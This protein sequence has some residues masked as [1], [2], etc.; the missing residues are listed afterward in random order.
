MSEL[1]ARYYQQECLDIIHAKNSG[2]YLVQMCC[3]AG[4]TFTFSRIDR[5]GRV[6]IMAHRRELVSQ[7]AKYYGCEVGYE[8]GKN[9]SNGEEVVVASVQT[10]T[11]RLDRFDPSDFDIIIIDEAHNYKAKTFQKVIDYFTP[12]LCL[13][14]TATPNRADGQGLDDIFEEIIFE[15]PI[16]RG[17]KEGFLVPIKCKR[18]TL[19]YDLENI[20]QNAGDYNLNDLSDRMVGT[21]FGISQAHKDHARGKTLVFGVDVDHCKRISEQ[22]P[23]SKYLHGGTSTKEREAVLHDFEHGDLD[24]LVNCMLFTEG[25]DIPCIETI[26]WARPTKSETLYTQ[27]VCRGARLF[28][29]KESMLLIDC[30]DA[31]A[32]CDLCSAPTLLGIDIDHLEKRKQDALEEDLFNLPDIVAVQSDNLKQWIKNVKH[33]DLWRKKKKYKTHNVNYYKFPNGEL[34]VG[35]PNVGSYKIRPANSL[36]KTKVVA[37]NGGVSEPM[38]MQQAFD[39]LHMYLRKNHSEHEHLWNMQIVKK[40]GKQKSTPAQ[41]AQVERY[42][43]PPRRLTKMEASCV[44][45]RKW[46]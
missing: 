8:Q 2:S 27:G 43:T 26:I 23:N 31:S 6:L 36:G 13:G 4:K 42:C 33:F 32:N 24:C 3:G 44:L 35:V 38:T 18:V 12:R 29:G 34:R 9:T 39:K 10:L 17:I 37:P 20:K 15:F 45:Q 30:V 5:Q 22:I 7:A 40:W 25:T 14:F 28:P 16:E 21:E 1:K 41:M 19:D 11:K 46:L